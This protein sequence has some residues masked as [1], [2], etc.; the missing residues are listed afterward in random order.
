M[1]FKIR[2]SRTIRKRLAKRKGPRSAGSIR[3]D[4]KGLSVE[5]ER[6]P[7]F[8]GT[9]IEVIHFGTDTALV[10]FGIFTDRVIVDGILPRHASLTQRFN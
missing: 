1:T 5:G 7:F 3:I 9:E 10:T 2:A 4:R 8:I 6:L